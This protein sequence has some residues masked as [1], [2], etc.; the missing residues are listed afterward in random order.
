MIAVLAILRSLEVVSSRKSF[1][2]FI[3]LSDSYSGMGVGSLSMIVPM[4]NAECA[5]PE[6]RGSLVSLQQVAIE[7]GIM[8]SFWID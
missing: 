4:Y 5:P 7:I 1:V 6:V 8:V 3:D 2:H